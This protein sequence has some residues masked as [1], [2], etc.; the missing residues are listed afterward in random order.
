MRDFNDADREALR[1]LL[2]LPGY[3]LLIAHASEEWTLSGLI[4]RI[5][6]TPD[7]AESILSTS[8]AVKDMLDWPRRVLRPSASLET[9]STPALTVRPRA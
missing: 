9:G 4:A 6:Q 3:Q 5:A 1:E 2:S 7:K 8:Q